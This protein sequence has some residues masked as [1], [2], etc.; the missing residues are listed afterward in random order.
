MLGMRI[1]R[2]RSLSKHNLR[3]QHGNRKDMLCRSNPTMHAYVRLEKTLLLLG[4]LPIPRPAA[5][6][7]KGTTTKTSMWLTLA[8]SGSVSKVPSEKP[9][10]PGTDTLV[11]GLF[12]E[13][14]L[15]C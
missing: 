3:K 13:A 1:D 6:A 2:M 10:T 11:L 14:M 7:C 15:Y 12:A 4:P 9:R 8:E 5:A